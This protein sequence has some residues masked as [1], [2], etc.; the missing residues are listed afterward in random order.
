MH[1]KFHYSLGGTCLVLFTMLAIMV[2]LKFQKAPV[3]IFINDTT[4]QKFI[5]SFHFNLLTTLAKYINVG[6]G[7]NGGLVM[8]FVFVILVLIFKKANRWISSI[9][10]LT[11]SGV[12]I[13]LNTEIKNLVGRTRPFVTQLITET[14]KSFPSGHSTG[15]TL[16]IGG[17]FLV[18][19]S[20]I[21]SLPLK[22]L[23]G[24][25]ASVIVLTVMASRVYLGVHYPTDTIAGALFGLSILHLS[26][27]T[28][29]KYSVQKSR[30]RSR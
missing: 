4:I 30:K 27:P 17:L 9:Y 26:Y 18:I 20:N 25:V 14:D 24:I 16:L 10:L 12:G 11:T 23:L 19:V 22:V 2:H 6:F 3:N 1:K 13:S 7:P 8:I 21:R 29:Y 28:F 5:F 15:A